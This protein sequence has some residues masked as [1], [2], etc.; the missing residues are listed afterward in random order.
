M[1]NPP[2]PARPR[3]R[4]VAVLA[5]LLATGGA[6]A[7]SSLQSG[8]HTKSTGASAHLDFKIV[9][10]PMLALRLEPEPIAAGGAPRVAVESNT[11][12]A[13]LTASTTVGTSLSGT[14]LVRAGRGVVLREEAGCR[15]AAPRPIAATAAGHGPAI[16][17]QRPVICTVALP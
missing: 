10:P 14:L 11:R 15:L 12:H 7:E 2:R 5:A 13:L 17:D 4:L 6:V 3:A 16:V 9:I 8:A 1:P